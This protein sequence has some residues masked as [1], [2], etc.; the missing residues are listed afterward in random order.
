MN[1]VESEAI[2]IILEQQLFD[3]EYYLQKNPDVGSQSGV[4]PFT[5]F[6]SH[7][8]FEGRDPHPLFDSSFYLE[9]NPAV[10]LMKV[11]PLVHYVTEGARQGL[12]P[13]RLFLVAYYLKQ[14]L[15]MQQCS[16]NPLI[17]YLEFGA[18]KGH[19]PHPLF[20]GCF[21][22]QQW[23]QVA[24]VPFSINPLVHY[25]TE[26]SLLGVSPSAAF[27]GSAYCLR[28][29]DV[30]AAGVNPLLHFVSVGQAEGRVGL[31]PGAS[32]ENP[33]FP[34]A[35]ARLQDAIAE[36]FSHL[37]ISSELVR[38]GSVR[39]ACSF[40]AAIARNV[41]LRNVL[42]LVTD[43]APVT[44]AGWLPSGGRIVNLLELEPTLSREDRGKLLFEVL[45][46]VKPKI[47]MNFNST[48]FWKAID[49][50]FEKGGEKLP[51]K[52]VAYLGGYEDYVDLNCHGFDDGPIKRLIDHL[53]LFVSD[54]ERLRFTMI[55]RNRGAA[56]IETKV[57]T[58]YKS[59]TDDLL[60]ALSCRRARRKAAVLV[61]LVDGT[62]RTAPGGENKKTRVLWASR[63]DGMK[64]P[65][66]LAEIAEKLPDVQFDVFGRRCLGVELGNLQFVPNVNLYGEYSDFSQIPIENC[67]AFLHTSN[68]DSMPHVLV[69][70]AAC[71][72]PIVAPRIGAIGELIDERTG[73]LVDDC[74]D[75]ISYVSVI[76]NVLDHSR[77]AEMRAD[78]LYELVTERHNW[79]AFLNRV[80]KLDIWN[81]A[82]L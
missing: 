45:S 81:F 79:L 37:L 43:Y 71:G 60:S 68:S 55:E 56:G 16:Y 73:W 7:G 66:L 41:G 59:L 18:A 40:A 22:S 30:A 62:E 67:S 77:E 23:E 11:N 35:L 12:D 32:Y 2:G 3:R 51:T 61:G 46:S 20:D 31:T 75:A 74:N 54:N 44:C 78:R 52:L 21:Y 42:F 15:S 19:N 48:I 36:P 9:R 53:D 24:G 14:G 6:L 38:G 39:C 65:A 69:E 34:S 29:P 63:L 25:L 64:Q 8:A 5:H 82:G 26:G 1:I 70:A 28:N 10:A 72:L 50:Y 13:H 57:V 58:C 80:D 4:D 76:R 17:H 33:H 47:A 49:E 27:D